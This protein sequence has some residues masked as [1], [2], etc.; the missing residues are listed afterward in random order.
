MVFRFR[1]CQDPSVRIMMQYL[2]VYMVLAD[3][4]YQ[5]SI[6]SQP[7]SANHHGST[8]RDYASRSSLDRC[9]RRTM[10]FMLLRLWLT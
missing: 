7:G 2:V 1:L 3:I 9:M 5:S 6:V 10:R 8:R 4:S